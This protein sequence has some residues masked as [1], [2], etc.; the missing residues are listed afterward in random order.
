[1]GKRRRK[2]RE[3]VQ[4]YL[5]HPSLNSKVPPKII[6]LPS[7]TFSPVSTIE[8]TP[9]SWSFCNP[10]SA[11]LTVTTLE[12]TTQTHTHIHIC[13]NRSFRLWRNGNSKNKN[14]SHNAIFLWL[15]IIKPD[16]HRRGHN[17]TPHHQP[18]LYRASDQ[19]NTIKE[20]FN[21]FLVQTLQNSTASAIYFK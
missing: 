9:T 2:R 15:N 16:S 5:P 20:S 18:Y 3:F 1:M 21:Y 14:A 13:V 6:L 8:S 19:S 10:I 4:L 7:V 12:Q 11:S 17:L